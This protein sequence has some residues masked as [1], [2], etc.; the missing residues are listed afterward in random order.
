MRWVVLLQLDIE[1]RL[2]EKFQVAFIV[3][4]VRFIW[5]RLHRR[6]VLLLCQPWA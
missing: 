2:P 3:L 5:H 4:Q 6:I 1:G